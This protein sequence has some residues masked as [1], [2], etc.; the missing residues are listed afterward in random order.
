MRST[1]GCAYDAHHRGGRRRCAAASPGSDLFRSR[2]GRADLRIANL[3]APLTTGGVPAAKLIRLQSPLE[4]AQWL[5][6]DLACDVVS[7]A[8]NHIMD[9]GLPGLESSVEA[10]STERACST[11]RWC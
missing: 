9:W 1:R 11:R 8:N 6:D 3:E 4:A 2:L 7:L 5:R 10:R